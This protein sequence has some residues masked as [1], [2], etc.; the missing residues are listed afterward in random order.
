MSMTDAEY[1]SHAEATYKEA[2]EILRSNDGWAVEKTD[3]VNN[4]TVEMK[5]NSKGKKIYRCK[6]KINMPANMLID[7]IKDTDNICDWN[8]TLKTSKVLKKLNDS[9]GISYQVTTDAAGGMV[10]S[11]D[12][13]YLY[14]IGWEG[15]SWAMGGQSVEYVDAPKASGIVRAINGPGLQM[16]TPTEMNDWCEIVWLMD[17]EYK[18]MML[19]K[20]LDIAL[21]MACTT[22]MECLRTLAADLKK[23]GKF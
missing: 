15:Q 1:I 4:V 10:S 9:I 23:Q 22:Y 12:F 20:I 14:K 3:D 19:Q 18:G 5:K 17:V 6:A 7:H 2:L 8:K 13:V 21:P 11:R 16:V